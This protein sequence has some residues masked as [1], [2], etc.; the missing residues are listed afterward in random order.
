MEVEYHRARCMSVLRVSVPVVTSNTLLF[1][2]GALVVC[3]PVQMSPPAMKTLAAAPAD[4]A[5]N[6][7]LEL[8]KMSVPVLLGSVRCPTSG[9]PVLSQ[10]SYEENPLCWPDVLLPNVSTRPSDRSTVCTDMPGQS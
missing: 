6:S 7:T 3:V 8:Q 10:M 2:F 4:S 1:W 5:G 9:A